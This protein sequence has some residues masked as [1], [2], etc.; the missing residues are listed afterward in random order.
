MTNAL[1]KTFNVLRRS[2]N[3]TV[4]VVLLAGLDSALTEIRENSVIGIVFRRNA[5]AHYE[6]I[7]RWSHLESSLREAVKVRPARLST[8][9]HNIIVD[10]EHK[11]CEQACQVALEIDE[12]DLIPP[13][14]HAAEDEN[15]VHRALLLQTML[16]LADRLQYQLSQPRNYENKRDPQLMRVHVVSALETSVDQ[17]ERHQLQEI[18][19]AFLV[20]SRHDN[21]T[22]QKI[23]ASPRHKA[24]P[25]IRDSF[26]H[27]QRAGVMRV[28]VALLECQPVSKLVLDTLADR[29]DA[30]FVARFAAVVPDF[31]DNTIKCMRRIK[32]LGL[33]RCP[34]SLLELESSQQAAVVGLLGSMGLPDEDTFGVYKVILEQGDVP[35][36]RIAAENLKRFRGSDA[37]E[38]AVSAMAD[39]D[40]DVQAIV[41]RQIRE[42][43]VPD[44]LS[45]LIT[46]TESRYGI[47]R[48]AAQE[49]LGEFHFERFVAVFEILSDEMKQSTGRLVRRADPEAVTKLNV[50]LESRSRMKRMRGLQIAVAIEAVDDAIE[51][52]IGRLADE[53]HFV[54]AEAAKA[55]GHSNLPNARDALR[56]ALL[57]RSLAVQDAAESSLYNITHLPPVNWQPD[58]VQPDPV[59]P[60]PVQ[61]DPAQPD[62]AQPTPPQETSS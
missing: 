57:D 33:T 16:K 47:V 58:P 4:G 54:R 2:K 10:P 53:D 22:L 43:G 28:I 30:Q 14:A 50:E 41:T 3:D 20:L 6:L 32:E 56:D 1:E 9:L 37:N 49:S 29:E 13:L 15:H 12:Y 21:S 23:L 59:Q 52:I 62:P 27:S 19:E 45:L 7:Q 40:P 26:H 8:T 24:Y 17:F 5:A 39:A 48:A 51:Q 31:G 34:E 35:A 25:A 46:Q 61:P 42:R 18:V 60:D 11:L 55:L 36:R 44:A 38:L